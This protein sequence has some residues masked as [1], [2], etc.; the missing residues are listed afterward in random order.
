MPFA[1]WLSRPMIDGAGASADERGHHYRVP[2]FAIWL[3][4]RRC[5]NR[6]RLETLDSCQRQNGTSALVGVPDGHCF[7]FADR[8]SRR[9]GHRSD[10]TRR[11]SYFPQQQLP[12]MF[13]ATQRRAGGLRGWRRQVVPNHAHLGS[14]HACSRHPPYRH[15]GHPPVPRA[16]VPWRRPH[17]QWVSQTRK[18]HPSI[19]D[20]GSRTGCDSPASP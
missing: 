9:Q 4:A 20:H 12:G 15:L 11:N 2:G 19:A 18:H 7:S 1:V 13:A 16:L 5:D 14:T 8:P 17:P 10:P 6:L 3:A